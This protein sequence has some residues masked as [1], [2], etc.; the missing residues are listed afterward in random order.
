MADFP[1]SSFQLDGDPGSIRTS[2][3]KYGS[4][5]SDATGAAGQVRSLDS[6]LFIGP[7]GDQYRQ[8]LNGDLPPHLETT[9]QAYTMVANALNT[10]ATDLSGLQDRMR[11]LASQ[12][13]SLWAAMQ[14]AEQA[15]STAKSADTT[16]ATSLLQT[17]AA[18]KPG[19]Q[20]PTD[21]YHSDTGAASSSLSS[22]QQAWTT[23]LNA[24]NKVK[25]DLQTDIDRCDHQIHIAS[26]MRFHKNPSGWGAM[27]AGF[28]GFVKDHV[29]GLAKLSGVLKTISAVAGVLSLVPGLDVIAAPVALAA[30][31]AALVIDASIKLATGQGSWKSIAIDG[32]LMALPGVGKL[33]SKGIE[34]LRG[35]KILGD[36]EVVF[37]VPKGATTEE[38]AQMHEYTNAANAA[39]KDG[40]LSPT[41]RVPVNGELKVAKERAAAVERTRAETSGT[42]YGSNHAA[43]L[44]TQRG[45]EKRTR[46][47]GGVAIHRESIP[48]LVLNPAS[49]RLDIGL[50]ASVSSR[51]HRPQADVRTIGQRC[52][53]TGIG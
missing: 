50:L 11:P 37:R 10:F 32:A 20:M 6:S 17:K 16:H 9:G 21:T 29:A 45:A 8:G 26:G 13:P 15:L 39:L 2:A 24:A 12:A 28:K 51:H 25:T 35:A 53:T 4:F 7:E 41:G 27:W 1:A 46:L 34:G 42:P 18:L 40:K 36:G 44:P 5:G 31:A 47:A 43:H 33:A 22:A 38:I 52:H 19:Q 49:I 30:G 48:V 14:H 3:S 23:C